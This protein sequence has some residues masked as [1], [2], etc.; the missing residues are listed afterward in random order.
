MSPEEVIINADKVSPSICHIRYTLNQTYFSSGTN[1]V[2]EYIQQKG[3]FEL[4]VYIIEE[5][6]KTLLEIRDLFH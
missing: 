1:P 5:S 3:S 2:L 4:E 6:R